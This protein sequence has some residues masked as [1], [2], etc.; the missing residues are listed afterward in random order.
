MLF[1]PVLLAALTAI[2]SLAQIMH[3]RQLAYQAADL[4]AL[5]GVQCLDLERLAVGQL[6]LEPESAITSALAYASRN[7]AA[8]GLDAS[9]PI[10][11]VRVLSPTEDGLP[12][13]ITGKIH[14]YPTVCVTVSFQ[15]SFRFGPVAWTQVIRAH[16]DASVV[17]R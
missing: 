12:D 16:A 13:P 10:I 4:A 9:G 14:Q 1:I 2:L 7:L 5:A 15:G 3:L 8:A 6:E 11:D 17:P